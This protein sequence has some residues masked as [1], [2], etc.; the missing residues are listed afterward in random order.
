[1]TPGSGTTKPVAVYTP[2]DGYYYR[3]SETMAPGSV[4]ALSAYTTTVSC[5]NNGSGATFVDNIHA[6]S[7]ILSAYPGD[8]IVCT[9]T[10]SSPP[11]KPTIT[12]SKALTG[13]RISDSD[14]FTVQLKQG[15]TLVASSGTT[16]G[17][18]SDI[19]SGSGTTGS[20]TATPGTAYILSEAMAAGSSSPLG[21][22]AATVS[23]QNN[24]VGGTVVSNTASW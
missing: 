21:S 2:D 19:T 14:Q 17:S 16:A 8:L 13:N 18:G 9:I 22:Y 23:C 1:V 10:N 12:L 24:A 3:M 11:G 6:L 7:D 20:F 5:K 15:S 4:S